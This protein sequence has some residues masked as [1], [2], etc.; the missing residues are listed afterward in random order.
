MNKSGT[1]EPVRRSADRVFLSPIGLETGDSTVPE[2]NASSDLQQRYRQFLD[3]LPLTIALSGLPTSE[4]RLY[5]EEQIEARA[6]TV[7]AAYRVAKNTA[8]ECL[9]GS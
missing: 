4:H 8:K 7:R 1:I 5:S 9:G 2:T 3:L 6:I